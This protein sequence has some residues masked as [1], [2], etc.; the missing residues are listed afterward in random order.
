MTE[1]N[2]V[3]GTGVDIPPP[4]EEIVAAARA[5]PDHWFFMPDPHWKEAGVPPRWAV[6]GRWR[7]DESGTIVE[8]EDNEEYRP[9]PE[10]LG[11]PEPH[12]PVDA[13][14]QLAATGY[15]PEADVWHALTEASELVVVTGADGEPQVSVMPEGERA[16]AVFTPSPLLPREA[17]PSHLLLSVF[18]LLDRLPK[19]TDRLLYLS[20][21]APAVV[22]MEADVLR[23]QIRKHAEGERHTKDVLVTS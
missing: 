19:D 8:W 3:A 18:E 12:D 2:D 1:P 9:S 10:A 4:P 13:A 6:L 16:V 20:P 14:A 15:G 22:L 23:E 17:L 21:T 7:S 11:W 5:A